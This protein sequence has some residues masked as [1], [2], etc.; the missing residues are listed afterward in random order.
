[1]QKGKDVPVSGVKKILVVE[2]DPQFRDLYESFLSSLGYSV[3]TKPDGKTALEFLRKEKVD[4]IVSDL[5]M[6]DLD[7]IE[8]FLTLKKMNRTPPFIIIS[9]G[10]RVPAEEYRRV[11]ER[12]GVSV[13]LEKPILLEDLKKAVTA[14][15][16]DD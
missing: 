8:L 13:Y 5:L 6:P 11:I 9:G 4:L 10:G 1:M 12:L 15:L 14:L 16:G 2:D 7:G 3:T